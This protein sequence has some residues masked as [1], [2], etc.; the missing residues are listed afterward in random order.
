MGLWFVSA[1]PGE[2][3]RLTGLD[4]W[5]GHGNY[6]TTAWKPGEVV[7]DRYRLTVPSEVARTQAWMLQVSIH[8]TDEGKWLPLSQHGHIV[9][10]RA[11]LG[12]I[13][14]GAGHETP[15]AGGGGVTAEPGSIFGGAAVLRGGLAESHEALA[16]GA[17][18]VT[19]E[20][21]TTFGGAIV[22]RGA[23]VVPDEEALR[24]TLWWQAQA[25]LSGNYIVFVHLI[26]K[27]GQLVGTGDGPPLGGGFPTQM[28]RPGDSVVDEHLVPL[29]PDLATGS[30]ALRVGWYNPVTG[31]RLPVG[32]TEA[33]IWSDYFDL[34]KQDLPVRSAL[35][36]G[37]GQRP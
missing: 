12:W 28:W 34:G 36:G 32:D 3:S 15:T 24:L 4:T 8:G 25:P 13:R 9:G 26:D 27:D 22:L 23:R 35:S 10:D 17:G 19:T 7:V 30:Y 21:G 29:P 16:A 2:T 33:Y 20:P 6:P 1:V 5:P 18:G 31:A 37:S 11:L 14:V